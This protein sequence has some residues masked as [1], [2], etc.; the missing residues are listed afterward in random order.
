MNP[1]EEKQAWGTTSYTVIP[2]S[3][4][5][6]RTERAQ[7][8]L[9]TNPHFGRMLFIDGVLQSTTADEVLYHRKLVREGLGYVP[10]P[11]VLIVG[12][13]EGATLR[14]VQNFDAEVNLGVRGIVMVDW[15][16]E[17]V[18]HMDEEEPWSQGSY[19]DDRLTL[20]TT[21]IHEYLDTNP[22]PFNTILIDL[23]DPGSEEETKWLIDV[24]ER[25]KRVCV[26][27][28]RIIMNCGPASAF[29]RIQ[30]IESAVAGSQAKKIV[31]YVPS[32]MEPWMLLFFEV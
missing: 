13:A 2:N 10:S 4:K 1:F 14:E 21:D 28:G 32:F 16:G 22:Q 7:I 31:I 15:D 26:K 8:D 12:G 11:R 9:V 27:G 23:L 25:C 24:V 20:H 29:D 30:Q 18:R 17:L 3:H 19:D 6:F 5:S